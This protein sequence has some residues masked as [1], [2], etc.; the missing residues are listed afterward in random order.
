MRTSCAPSRPSVKRAEGRDGRSCREL[1]LQARV[2]ARRCRPLTQPRP[3]DSPQF[4]QPRLAA[5]CSESSVP[6][7][8]SRPREPCRLEAR[9]ASETRTDAVSSQTQA[10]TRILFR[11]RRRPGPPPT[12]A[13]GLQRWSASICELI[14]HARCA[15]EGADVGAGRAGQF[16]DVK[17]TTEQATVRPRPRPRRPRP[18]RP[19]RLLGPMQTLACGGRSFRV[20]LA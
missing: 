19:G 8:G 10:L 18:R 1:D 2:E 4:R 3:A 6:H 14:T 9:C 12:R 20:I 15:R 13:A 11:V 17:K 7:A 5:R 16:D